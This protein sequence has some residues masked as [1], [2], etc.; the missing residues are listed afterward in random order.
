MV[1]KE[2]VIMGGGHD[3]TERYFQPTILY[4]VDWTDQVM[5]GEIFGPVLSVLRYYSL[6]EAITQIKSRPRPLAG[7][8]FSKD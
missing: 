8:I 2:K 6:H 4:P 7:Y 3:E 5:Q 1:D